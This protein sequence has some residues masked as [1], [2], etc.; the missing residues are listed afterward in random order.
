MKNLRFKKTLGLFIWMFIIL[1][2]FNTTFTW[3]NF[4]EFKSNSERH[5]EEQSVLIASDIKNRYESVS[6][7]VNAM[8]PFISDTIEKS[9][10]SIERDLEAN[11]RQINNDILV[12]LRKEYNLTN[13]YVLN[14]EGVVTHATDQREVGKYSREFYNEAD[15]EKWE[16]TF[17]KIVETKGIYVEDKFYRSEINPYRY[18]KWGYKGVGYIDGFGFVVLEVGLQVMDIK[19]ESISPLV[20][21]VVDLEKISKNIT[22]LELINLPPTKSRE[23]FKEKQY[24]TKNGD[25]ITVINLKGL[26]NSDMQAIITTEFPI[27]K[28]NIEDSFNNASIWT[29]FYALFSFLMCLLFYYRFSIPSQNSHEDAIAQSIHNLDEM[30]K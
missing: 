15:K 20:D 5:Q 26:D 27:M 16:Q 9:L 30:Q 3:I 6:T 8:D 18:H 19:D 14:E 2:F 25:V 7:F 4:Y 11:G 24:R 13:I 23:D 21:Q 1:F 28:D 17:K 10:Y 22:K 12:S 29:A